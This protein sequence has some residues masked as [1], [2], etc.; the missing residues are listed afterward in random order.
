MARLYSS[1]L[2]YLNGVTPYIYDSG[3]PAEGF[4][5]IARDISVNLIGPGTSGPGPSFTFSSKGLAN[6]F[7]NVSTVYCQTN[8]SYH[9]EGR[10]VINPGDSLQFVFDATTADV[11]VNGYILST[12]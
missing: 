12:P 5:W 2:W 6:T 4:I 10:K 7:W 11:C 3:G 9:W 1:E 8:R